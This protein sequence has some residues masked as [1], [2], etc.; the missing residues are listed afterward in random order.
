[1]TKHSRQETMRLEQIML[2]RSSLLGRAFATFASGLLA[3]ECQIWR[4]RSISLLRPSTQL[5]YLGEPLQ[6]PSRSSPYA[7]ATRSTFSRRV[8]GTCSITVSVPVSRRLAHRRDD[9]TYCSSPACRQFS[10][11]GSA[12]TSV[13]PSS[14]ATSRQPQRQLLAMHSVRIWYGSESATLRRSVRA[15]PEGP[16]TMRQKIS[17]LTI[18]PRRL[19][20]TP[21]AKSTRPS[22]HARSGVFDAALLLSRGISSA[23]YTL[24]LFFQSD[25]MLQRPGHHYGHHPWT[26]LPSL[27]S[28]IA[29]RGVS[30]RRA[31]S[32]FPGAWRDVGDA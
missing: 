18:G 15:F 7:S 10:Q 6:K 22:R 8:C 11:L 28:P 19:V 3:H 32:V 27:P 17:G 13:R 1:M 25:R 2:L 16:A 12:Q 21:S 26:A 23:A 30:R 4:M 31:G 5:W 24:M 20:Q 14:R 9:L 29:P